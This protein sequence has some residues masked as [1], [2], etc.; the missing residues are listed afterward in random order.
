MTENDFGLNRLMNF[1]LILLAD[2]D[3]DGVCDEDEIFGY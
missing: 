1:V 3:L 2:T